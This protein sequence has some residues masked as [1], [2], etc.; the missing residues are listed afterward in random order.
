MPDAPSVAYLG[1]G[2]S[3]A[4]GTRSI[5]TVTCATLNLVQ[6]G[7]DL[8]RFLGF[9]RPSR[10]LDHLFQGLPR[11]AGIVPFGVKVAK[12]KIWRW[13]VGRHSHGGAVLLQRGVII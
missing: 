9:G 2:M 12:V 6:G 11:L 5:G 7:D 1:S 13:I 4:P 8:A 10:Y 3:S